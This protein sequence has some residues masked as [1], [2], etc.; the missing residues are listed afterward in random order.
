MPRAIPEF[1]RLAEQYEKRRA[2]KIS[3]FFT[4]IKDPIIQPYLELLR[5]DEVKPTSVPKSVA[6]KFVPPP[7]FKTGNGVR[8]AIRALAL[9]DR[10]DA[11]HVWEALHKRQFRFGARDE[12]GAVADALYAMSRGKNPE[13]RRIPTEGGGPTQYEKI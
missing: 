7:G 3:Q 9:Q 13:F 11:K 12:V 5:D 10:F 8:D 2:E 4:L 1:V 6:H